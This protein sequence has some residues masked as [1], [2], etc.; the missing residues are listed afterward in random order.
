MDWQQKAAALNALAEIE[1]KIR[2]P[3]D[4]YCS[5]H[6][7]VKNG[8]C[9]ESCFGNG[10]SPEE[11]VNDHWTQ[12]VDDLTPKKYLVVNAGL[13][14][15]RAVKWNGFMWEDIFEEGRSAA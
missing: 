9:L 5:N 14:C 3:G 4:W 13:A 7:E 10:A 12:A 2:K 6:V 11:A 8:S 15:R 1:I